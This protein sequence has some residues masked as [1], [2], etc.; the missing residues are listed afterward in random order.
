MSDRQPAP[1][2]DPQAT[3]A[4]SLFGFAMAA[5]LPLCIAFVLLLLAPASPTSAYNQ[6]HRLIVIGVGAATLLAF[7]GAVW[8][9][10][11][12]P[13]AA[14]RIAGGLIWLLGSRLLACLSLLG[15]LELNILAAALLPDIAPVITGPARFLLFCW[16]LLYAG[17][18]LTIHRRRVNLAFARHQQWLAVA[19]LVMG[20]LCLAALLMIMTARLLSDSGWP[21]R[22]R[23]ALDY[24]PLRFIDD[25]NAPSPQ[26]FWAEQSQ[27]RVRWLPYSY[28]V[29]APVDGQFIHVDER[30]MRHTQTVAD[31]PGLPS[32]VFFGGSTIWGEGARDAH[33]I[34]SQVSA[35]LAERDQPAIVRNYGQTGYVSA[36]DLALFQRQ[37]AM[38]ERPALAVFYQGFNDIYSAY[39]QGR[40]GL[41]ML[42]R[43]RLDDAEA[44]RL[45][46]QGQPILRQPS[47]SL[48]DV[49]WRLAVSGGGAAEDIID[50]WLANRRL[51]RGAAAEFGVEPLFV[52][53]PALFAKRNLSDFEVR[54]SRRIE[55]ELP[56]FLALYAQVD[57][58]LRQRAASE[59]WDDLIILSDL[60]ADSDAEIFFDEAHINEIGNSAV[61]AAIVDEIA[62]RLRQ[63]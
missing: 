38:G 33:T 28:W 60:F 57:A 41:P 26:D 58:L 44:G 17:L 6:L 15:L 29:V 52:W 59:S 25:G 13:S 30:G 45:L 53:Q 3:L 1:V 23:G 39:T 27:T 54:F 46:R 10:R 37:L 56:G 19:S 43:Q 2:Y 55:R 5:W 49:D 32:L 24:R 35:L 14:G 50:S 11:L 22:L 42:E 63:D 48:D 21:G 9:Y 31:A 7:I 62:S 51:I 8:I 20:S 4:R 36:Q 47:G 18:L 61:A 34:P 12:D 40:A 16:S